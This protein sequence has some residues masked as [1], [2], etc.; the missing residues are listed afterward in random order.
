MSEQRKIAAIYRKLRISEQDS[1]REY[2]LSQP[3]DARL[4]ALEEIQ[5]EYHGGEYDSEPS[6]ISPKVEPS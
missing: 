6:S 4:A 1:G 2:R 5:R 3:P